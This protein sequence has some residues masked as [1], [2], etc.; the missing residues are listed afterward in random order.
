[1]RGLPGFGRALE[2][3]ADGLAIGH[4][5]VALVVLDGTLPDVQL[6]GL[7]AGDG[8]VG[9]LGDVGR[10]DLGVGLGDGRYAVL[11]VVVDLAVLPGAIQHR[12][13]ALDVMDAP[14][15]EGADE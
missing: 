9:Q 15:P 5:D 2:G 4:D 6:A 13:H 12:L 1:G 10:D 14:H 11:H 3:V 8:V 7:Q